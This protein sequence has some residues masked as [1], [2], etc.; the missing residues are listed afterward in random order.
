MVIPVCPG[1]HVKAIP[2]RVTGSPGLNAC[3]SLVVIVAT[4]VG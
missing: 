3:G 4:P 2:A 1:L